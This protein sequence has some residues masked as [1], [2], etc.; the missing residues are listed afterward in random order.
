MSSRCSMMVW[1]A[2]LRETGAV[3]TLAVN[4][5]DAQDFSGVP[6]GDSD[7]FA[8]G[9]EQLAAHGDAGA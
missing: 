9:V 8:V 2:W 1:P 4:G 7:A 3:V 6:V 5:D